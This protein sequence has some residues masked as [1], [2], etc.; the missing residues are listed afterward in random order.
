MDSVWIEHS[1]GMDSVWG[2]Y[3]KSNAVLKF[4]L[5]KAFFKISA[6]AGFVFI[7]GF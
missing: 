5:A 7:M 1:K 4:D 3:E 6:P 2:V